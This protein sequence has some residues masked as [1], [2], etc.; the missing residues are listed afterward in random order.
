MLNGR[1]YLHQKR[2]LLVGQMFRMICFNLYVCRG[3][4]EIQMV[5]ITVLAF[6][7]RVSDSTL[8]MVIW[9]V[10]S[11]MYAKFKASVD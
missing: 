6:C 11:G 5:D 4:H 3:I 1:S 9:I 10:Q 8:V 2:H 7:S